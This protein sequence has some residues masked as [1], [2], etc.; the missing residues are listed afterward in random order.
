M[1]K[2][3]YLALMCTGLL[4]LFSTIRAQSA[5]D[6]KNTTP[7]QRAQLQTGMMKSKLQLSDE[8]TTKVAAINLKY[9]KQMEPVIKGEGSKLS[10]YREAKKINEQKDAE[11]KQVFT[12]D[13]FSRYEKAKEEMK[14]A[15]KKKIQ[16]KRQQ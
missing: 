14:E 9:A 6:F 7:E 11:L 3:L 2:Y 13:Q 16:E 5:E 10:K 12:E 8:Q 1:K 4:L 15:M